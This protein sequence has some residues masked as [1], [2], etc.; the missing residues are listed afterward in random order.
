MP[1][2]LGTVHWRVDNITE[3]RAVEEVVREEREKL[4]DFTD[5]A[6][7][8]FYALDEN[9]RFTFVNATLARWL[10]SDIDTL[11]GGGTMHSYLD[12]QFFIS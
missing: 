11:L 7:V 5:H 1:G 6:P 3:R 12:H 2:W 8:G 10:G 9:G 4:V